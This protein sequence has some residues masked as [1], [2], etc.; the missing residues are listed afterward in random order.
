MSKNQMNQMDTYKKNSISLYGTYNLDLIH[1]Y[2]YMNDFIINN[3][4]IGFLFIKF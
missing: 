2:T 1:F 4:L 3:K